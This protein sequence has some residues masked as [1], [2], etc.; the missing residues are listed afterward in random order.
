MRAPSAPGWRAGGRGRLPAA[1][2]A[3]AMCVV[4]SGCFSEEPDTS[5]PD[6]DDDVVV[7]RMTPQQTFEPRQVQVRV[8]QTIRWRNDSNVPHTATADADLAIDAG[9]V[10][11]PAGADT[12]DSGFIAPG[13]SY[14]LVLTVAGDY[15]YFC[16]PHE[17]GGMLGAISVIP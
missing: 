17:Q 14:D 11:L 7:I 16:V 15:R 12:W 2:V 3:A 8:G 9:H 10:E 13:A 1:L 5:A 6:D 4:V